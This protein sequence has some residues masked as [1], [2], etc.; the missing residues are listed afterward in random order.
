M[1]E[2][3]AYFLTWTT[4]GTWLPGDARRWVDKRGSAGTPY[5]QG[6][7]EQ[8]AVARH[9]MKQAAVCLDDAPRRLVEA[10]IRETC[11]Q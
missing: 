2:P 10:A 3:L 4:Y 9:R 5:R 8:V 7:P 11:R 1:A 6:D